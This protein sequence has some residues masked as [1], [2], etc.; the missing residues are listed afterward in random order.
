MMPAAVDVAALSNR[1]VGAA[2]SGGSGVSTTSLFAGDWRRRARR[3]SCS[4]RALRQ[5]R[6]SRSRGGGL[7]IVCNLGGQYE[8][9]FDDVQLQLMNYFTYKAVRTVLTQLYEMNPPS[10]R[11][12]YNFV[13]V[14]KPTEGKLFL[15]ALSKE[16]QE[17]AERVMITRL[18]LYGKWIKDRNFEM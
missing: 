17:L 8:D 10:Y 2:P 5:G 1:R 4:V 11:W 18:H 14:N 3:P 9:T 6:S 13:A 15:R 12:F 7:G 16:R